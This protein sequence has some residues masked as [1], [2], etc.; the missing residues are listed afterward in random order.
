MKKLLAIL[1]VTSLSSILATQVIACDINSSGGGFFPNPT[2]HPKPKP[3][4]KL[5][6]ISDYYNDYVGHATNIVLDQDTRNN[7]SSDDMNQ[8]D[9]QMLYFEL[10]TDIYNEYAL[11]LYDIY[12]IV[13]INDKDNSTDQELISTLNNIKNI[14]QNYFINGQ[15]PDNPTQNTKDLGGLINYSY[16]ETVFDSYINNLHNSD[17]T[18][19]N[20]F[21]KILLGD[22]NNLSLISMGSLFY[23]NKEQNAMNGANKW[24][25]GTYS[26]NEFN[27]II[28][29]QNKLIAEWDNWFS[30]H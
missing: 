10:E 19:I 30:T 9:S 7:F 29:E 4:P 6:T 16:V 23:Y 11:A 18:I 8:L 12:N 28:K 1:S 27:G 2:P 20:N 24:V 5:E 25:E 22:D 15:I 17:H 21:V 3:N 13:K 26:K 14:N